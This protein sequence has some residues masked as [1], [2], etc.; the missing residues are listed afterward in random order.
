MSG[1]TGDTQST[2]DLD[3]AL[4]DALAHLH[5]PSYQMPPTLANL[6]GTIHWDPAREELIRAIQELAPRPDAPTGSPAARFYAILHGRYV[7][8]HTQEVVAEQ[9]EISVRH[10]RRQ[11]RDAVQWLADRL[12]L[13]TAAP[14]DQTPSSATPWMA[15]VRQE[16]DALREESSSGASMVGDVITRVLALA[17]PVLAKRGVCL[18]HAPGD[19]DL[20]VGVHATSLRQVLLVTLDRMTDAHTNKDHGAMATIGARGDGDHVRIVITTR[21]ALVKERPLDYLVEEIL[22][23]HQGRAEWHAD[24]EQ[25]SITFELYA[26]RPCR[27]LVVDDNEDL[28]HFYRRFAAGTPYRIIHKPDGS[29]IVRA[30]R[31]ASAEI[32]V[33]D[34][35]LPDVDGWELLT[36]LHQHPNTRQIPVLVCTVVR[37]EEL[38]T[39]LG[40]AAYL[41]KPV[42]RSEF[43]EALRQIRPR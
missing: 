22:A 31:E 17:E 5:D 6:L 23:I 20:M 39:A 37:A 34:V 26:V 13:P 9:L 1:Q 15:Q 18:T 14:E 25:A 32:V 29:D 33:L 38:A 30:V 35:M 2:D 24:C 8:G 42:R 36:H 16:L 10:L 3:G 28:V 27:V 11:Q 21:P 4:Q 43:I 19:P 40:A 7:R 12:R 41:V